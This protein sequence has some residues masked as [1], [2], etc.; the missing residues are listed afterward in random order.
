MLPQ[1]QRMHYNHKLGLLDSDDNL[2]EMTNSM[3]GEI[4][5]D[6]YIEVMSIWEG[7]DMLDHIYIN[8]GHKRV[9]NMVQSKDE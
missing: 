9:E 2:H 1:I 8:G 3:M 6:Y 4:L 5:F 7:M